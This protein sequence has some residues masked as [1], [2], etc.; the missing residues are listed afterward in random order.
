MLLTTVPRRRGGRRAM[1]APCRSAR[2]C[3][4]ELREA[5]QQRDCDAGGDRPHEQ[6]RERG[7][8]V[9]APREVS[10]PRQRVV[11]PDTPECRL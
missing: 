5:L 1:V 11:T 9:Q 7:G 10:A 6:V 2:T 3:G 8:E 4:Q